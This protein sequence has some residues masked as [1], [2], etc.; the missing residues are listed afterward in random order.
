MP[1]AAPPLRCAPP[2]QA[3]QQASKSLDGAEVLAREVREASAECVTFAVTS[4]A[5]EEAR[6]YHTLAT[7]YL[8]RP[9]TES[10]TPQQSPDG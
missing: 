4:E 5:F 7:E 1:R 9:L 10:R 8:G 3:A 6:Y 2:A